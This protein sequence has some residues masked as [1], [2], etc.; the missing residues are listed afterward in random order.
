MYNFGPINQIINNKLNKNKVNK[1][2]YDNLTKKVDD[3]TSAINEVA[4][5]KVRVE[6]VKQ[7]TEQ[8]INQYIILV[9]QILL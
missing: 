5:S 4:N 7:T 8:T 6:L 9:L 3:N 1:T 2:D